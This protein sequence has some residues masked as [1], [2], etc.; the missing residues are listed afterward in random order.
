MGQL[1]PHEAFTL[2]G[3]TSVRGYREGALGTGARCAPAAARPQQPGWPPGPA[4]VL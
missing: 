4:H 1:Q 3:A 2:G